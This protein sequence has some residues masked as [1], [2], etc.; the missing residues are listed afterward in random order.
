MAQ[1]VGAVHCR[2][3]LQLPSP[4][5]HSHLSTQT[6]LLVQRNPVWAHMPLRPLAQLGFD[7]LPNAP[8][9]GGICGGTRAGRCAGRRR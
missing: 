4:K 5:D 1:Q 2:P 9:Q 7:H 8:L 3:A 6:A